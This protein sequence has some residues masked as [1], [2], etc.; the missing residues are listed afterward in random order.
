MLP[1]KNNFKPRKSSR[2]KKI[3]YSTK[4]YSNPFFQK[5]RKRKVRLSNEVSLKLKLIFFIVLVIGLFLG[6]LL[7]YSNYFTVTAITSTGEG[8]I[9]T[10]KITDTAWKQI[11]NNMFI[12]WPQ[13]N[14][15]LFNTTLL[16]ESLEKKYSF[17]YLDIK[18]KFPNQITI[19]YKEKS[20]SL[21]WQ[22]GENYYYADVNGAV[23]SETNLLEIEYKDYPLIKN[24]AGYRI[25]E[26]HLNVDSRYLEAAIKLFSELKK[27]ELDFT[28][29]RFILDNEVNTL[30][31]QTLNGPQIYFNIND[32]LAKQI[33]K[34]L[35]VKREKIKDNFNN[36]TYIDL[37]IGDSVYYR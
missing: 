37:R 13:K 20:H 8:K 23:I 12:L 33:N 7:L 15:F 22:N 14:I 36:K 27:H 16:R 25:E 3:R 17:E 10:S 9:E 31:V 4:N 26:N 34:L 29:D 18:K 1:I 2:R 11:E 24:L 6:W 32:D 28:V 30:K 35:I 19:N 5:K 21:I